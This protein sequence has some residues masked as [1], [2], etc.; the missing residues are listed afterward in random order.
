MATSS[1]TCNRAARGLEACGAEAVLAIAGAY[2]CAQPLLAFDQSDW[3]CHE[4]VASG[5]QPW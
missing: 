5:T 4:P 1:T 2:C 3:I